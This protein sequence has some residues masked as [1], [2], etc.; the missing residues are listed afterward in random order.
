MSR[1]PLLPLPPPSAH[2]ES[3]D[4][5]LTQRV[6]AYQPRVQPCEMDGGYG[7][8]LKERRMVRL[9]TFQ[10]EH[11]DFLTKP[12]LNMMNDMSWPKDPRFP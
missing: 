4:V 10:D 5:R 11:R 7:C 6:N 12:E 1:P 3:A 8:A 9:H 2:R